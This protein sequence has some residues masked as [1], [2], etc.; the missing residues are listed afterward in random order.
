MADHTGFFYIVDFP[1]GNFCPIMWSTFLSKH[2]RFQD[3]GPIPSNEGDLQEWPIIEGFLSTVDFQ[4]GNLCPI[5]WSMFLETGE[6]SG[7]GT[8]SIE[9]RGSPRVANHI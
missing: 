4:A 2:A 8:N 1:T 7:P 9:T 6:V 3:L 5:L